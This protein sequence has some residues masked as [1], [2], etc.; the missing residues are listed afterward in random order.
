MLKLG[1][2]AFLS[3]VYLAR[4]LGGVLARCVMLGSMLTVQEVL[5][6]SRH[7]VPKVVSKTIK[8]YF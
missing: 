7:P 3:L 4:G 5:R 8:Y 1:E 2:I 6:R